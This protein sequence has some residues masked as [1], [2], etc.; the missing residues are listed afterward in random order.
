M[1][2]D[3]AD[4]V[5]MEPQKDI[6]NCGFGQSIAVRFSWDLHP[7]LLEVYFCPLR[8]LHLFTLSGVFVFRFC[9]RK[10]VGFGNQETGV[11][12][13]SRVHFAPGWIAKKTL[14]VRADRQ[15]FEFA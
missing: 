1:L 2:L 14:P 8:D 9:G 3:R 4:E 7:G 12:D 13:G 15:R 10:R 6:G 5:Q 11:C